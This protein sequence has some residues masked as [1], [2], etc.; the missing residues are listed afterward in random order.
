MLS[1]LFPLV[2]LWL[3]AR[4]DHRKA[5]L[6]YILFPVPLVTLMTILGWYGSTEW[7]GVE[8]GGCQ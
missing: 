3:N 2:A 1:L 4:S 6:L 8:G 7:L 5:A